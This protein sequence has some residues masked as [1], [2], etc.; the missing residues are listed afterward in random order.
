MVQ[1]VCLRCG[2]SFW[3]KP[4]KNKDGDWETHEYCLRCRLG[5]KKGERKGKQR[6]ANIRFIAD[7]ADLKREVD[8]LIYLENRYPKLVEKLR[9]ERD[10]YGKK[11][12][13]DKPVN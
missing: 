6:K 3:D 9:G 8:A 1:I 7:K 13:A 11:K 4:K 2:R 12:E 5:M 10:R